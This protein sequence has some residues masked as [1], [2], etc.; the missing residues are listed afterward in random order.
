MNAAEFAEHRIVERLC[1]ERQSIHACSQVA[2][3]IGKLERAGIC[4]H[5]YLDVFGEQETLP[6]EIEHA[7]DFRGR[8]QAG[9]TAAQEYADQRPAA[10]AC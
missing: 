3:W 10:G 7:A 1:A 8:E 6:Y 5:R 4:L 2:L 9:G